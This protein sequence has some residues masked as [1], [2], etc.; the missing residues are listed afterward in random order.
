[1]RVQV[2]SVGEPVGAGAVVMVP[3][4]VR[5]CGKPGQR[6]QFGSGSNRSQ[7]KPRHYTSLLAEN[8]MALGWL[9]G[10]RIRKRK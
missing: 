3:K 7:G 9:N 2:L 4:I 10:K 8:A 6:V 1:M 5:W